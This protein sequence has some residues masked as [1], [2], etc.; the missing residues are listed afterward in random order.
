MDKNLQDYHIK[1]FEMYIDNVKSYI[2]ISVGALILPITFIRE[3]TGNDDSPIHVDV[4]IKLSWASFLLAIAFGLLY[5]WLAV[6]KL[7]FL[8]EDVPAN[9]LMQRPGYAYGVMQFAFFA[10]SIFFVLSAFYRL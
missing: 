10:G 5:Q 2:Q 9:W 6:R 4:F 1:K 7:Q 8:V 3:L